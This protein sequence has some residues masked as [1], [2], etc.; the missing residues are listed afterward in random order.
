MLRAK[1]QE[2]LLNVDGAA[3]LEIPAPELFAER[4]IP[5]DSLQFDERIGEHAGPDSQ[6]V[7][8][9][10][11]GKPQN[12]RGGAELQIVC[13]VRNVGIPCRNLDALIRSFRSRTVRLFSGEDQRA[14]GLIGRIVRYVPD[15]PRAMRK[16]ESSFVLIANRKDP[17]AGED[18]P[19]DQ[20]R[21]HE[22]LE[23]AREIERCRR[24]LRSLSKELFSRIEQIVFVAC[25]AHVISCAIGAVSDEQNAVAI[26]ERYRSRYFQKPVK[27]PDRADEF[28]ERD[29]LGRSSLQVTHIAVDARAVGEKRARGT[30]M[31]H[32]RE[33]LRD[34]S[35]R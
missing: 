4:K 33:N 29:T 2:H 21:G 23:P 24:F 34:D 27:A 12:E 28:A 15:E 3:E 9:H 13:D 1:L 20:M 19:R 6:R 17:R 18:R 35:G 22:I 16:E 31:E 7:A 5:V 10:F 8:P 14:V 30:G 11:F 25:K 26:N 32:E